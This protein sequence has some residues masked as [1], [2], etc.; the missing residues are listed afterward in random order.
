M[1]RADC[2][3]YNKKEKLERLFSKAGEA[4]A[5]VWFFTAQL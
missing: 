4:E 5:V 3:V 1:A 2:V